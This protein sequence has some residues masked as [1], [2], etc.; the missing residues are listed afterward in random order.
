M[1]DTQPGDVVPQTLTFTADATVTRAPTPP[2]PDAQ[3][4]ASVTRED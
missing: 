4:A 2:T 3:A 1:A